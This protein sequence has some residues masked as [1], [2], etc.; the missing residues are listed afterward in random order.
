MEGIFLAS[1]K[2]QVATYL[3]YT[4]I[5][6]ERLRSTVHPSTLAKFADPKSESLAS[7]VVLFGLRLRRTFALLDSFANQLLQVIY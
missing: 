3:F 7:H 5:K 4:F 6:G 2:V 1:G